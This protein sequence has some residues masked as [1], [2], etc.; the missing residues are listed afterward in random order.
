MGRIASSTAGSGKGGNVG[1]MVA[2]GVTLWGAG[3]GGPSRITASAG[4]GSSG[5]A[6]DV[7]LTAGGAIALLGGGQISSET[8]G[9]GNGGTVQVSAQGPLTVSDPMSDIVASTTSSGHAGSVAVTAPQITLASGGAIASTTAGTGAGGSVN[10]ATP[11]ALILNGFSDPNT[12][13]AASATGT[14]SG[15]GG[16]VMVDAGTLRVQGGAQIASTTAGLGDGGLV[17]VTAHGPLTLSDPG[18]G[19]VA[20][21]TSRGNAGPVTVTAPQ[22]TIAS[23]GEIASTTAGTG[24]GGPAVDVTTP[25]ALVLD[26]MGVGGTQIAASAFGTSSGAGGRVTVDA[27][28]LTVQGGA[29]IAS[30]TAGAGNGGNVSVNVASDISLPDPDRK[31]PRGRPAAATPGRSP[32]PRFG[33]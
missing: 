24:M 12:Q 31:L 27:G 17:Q 5:Q 8:G 30:T 22:I 3:P 6:G 25:G 15:G 28:S 26:G 9:S 21:T 13:I 11:G 10:V 18:S 7:V 2:N 16:F 23:G 4:Q 20:S 32:S 33:C 1:V 14:Q 29:Q 19:I